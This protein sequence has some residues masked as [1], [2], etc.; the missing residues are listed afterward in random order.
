MVGDKG[1]WINLPELTKNLRLF[2]FYANA[3]QKVPTK[4]EAFNNQGDKLF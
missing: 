4:D 1:V 2:S 3:Q